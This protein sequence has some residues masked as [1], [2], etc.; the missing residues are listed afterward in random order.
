MLLFYHEIWDKFKTV[1]AL[2]HGKLTT[3]IAALESKNIILAFN[4]LPQFQNAQIVQDLIPLG[5][6]PLKDNV[7]KH[8]HRVVVTIVIAIAVVE[9]FPEGHHIITAKL[10]EIYHQI[11]YPPSSDKVPYR[12]VLIMESYMLL[13]TFPTLVELIKQKRKVRKAFR[14]LFDIPPGVSTAGWAAASV[15]SEV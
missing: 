7:E 11:F 8:M 4:K 10:K 2:C 13:K 14:E 6:I 5:L 3:S 9:A 1:D 15:S 12:E